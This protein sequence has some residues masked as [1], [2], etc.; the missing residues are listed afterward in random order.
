[1]RTRA[2]T[3]LRGR[4]LSSGRFGY[5]L[6]AAELVEE[7][8]ELEQEASDV[9][10]AAYYEAMDTMFGMCGNEGQESIFN[11][12]VIPAFAREVANTELDDNW[13]DVNIG[14]YMAFMG[15]IVA[16]GNDIMSRAYGEA[17]GLINEAEDAAEEAE[18]LGDEE[19]FDEETGEFRF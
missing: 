10:E 16:E 13:N 6:R 14:E 1:M 19:D 17:N 3:E 4:A 12:Q 7:A 5:G 8:A 9:V 18:E 15:E 11:S 2:R